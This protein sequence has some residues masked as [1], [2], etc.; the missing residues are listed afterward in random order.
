MLD[1]KCPTCGKK[2]QVNDEM[3]H[4]ECKHCGFQSTYDDYI[5]IM[6]SKAMSLADEFQFSS[7]NKRPF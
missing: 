5:E 2:A 4:V 7:S 3:S 6:R 1:A